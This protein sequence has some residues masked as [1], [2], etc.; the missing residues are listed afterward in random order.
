[1]YILP[2]LLQYSIRDQSNIA[3]IDEFSIIVT[4]IESEI[5]ILET[6]IVIIDET[7]IIER[8]IVRKRLNQIFLYSHGCITISI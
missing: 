8:I 4:K 7:S 1:M 5:S 6:I 3:R 2:Q